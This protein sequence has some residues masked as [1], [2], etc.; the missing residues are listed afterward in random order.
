MKTAKIK[1]STATATSR[2][3]GWWLE[4]QIQ[5]FTIDYNNESELKKG[6]ERIIKEYDY[7]LNKKIKFG[8]MYRDDEDGNATHTG[9]V[10]NIMVDIQGESYEWK[11]GYF[12][13]WIELENVQPFTL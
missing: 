1:N 12:E 8:R 9:Y 3:S 11:K 7:A 13:L 10:C 2:N 6:L 4:S 5:G